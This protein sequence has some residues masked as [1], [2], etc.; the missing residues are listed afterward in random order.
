LPED[1]APGSA[2][3]IQIVRRLAR[4]G[5]AELDGARPLVF[6]DLL[7]RAIP[8]HT[9]FSPETGHIVRRLAQVLEASGPSFESAFEDF[10]KRA[11]RVPFWTRSGTTGLAGDLLLGEEFREIVSGM[12]SRRRLE[13]FDEIDRA[14]F[15]PP[16]RVLDGRYASDRGLLE[17]FLL[18][19]QRLIAGA[20]QL[21]AW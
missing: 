21:A 6:D 5:V 15:A 2:V 11:G 4:L 1:M 19:R 18:A 10:S 9:P 12:E 14:A 20:E 16:E 7:E 13:I 8:R 3:G 17:L